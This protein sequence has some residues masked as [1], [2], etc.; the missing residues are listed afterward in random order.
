MNNIL[1]TMLFALLIGGGAGVLLFLLV[2][3]LF[4]KI[5]KELKKYG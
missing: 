5:N 2:Y 4:K 3:V 1:L